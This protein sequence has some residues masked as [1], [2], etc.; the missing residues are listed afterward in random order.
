MPRCTCFCGA[1]YKVP[2]ASLGKESQCKQCGVVFT[3]TEDDATLTVAPP[4]ESDEPSELAPTQGQLFA[5]PGAPGHLAN[6]ETFAASVPREVLRR[7]YSRDVLWTFL[8]PTSM[9]NLFAF[10]AI[11]FVFALARIAIAPLGFL[12]IIAWFLLFG[13][14]SAFRFEIIGS[15]A[16]GH[17]D[18]PTAMGLRNFAA[19]LVGPLLGWIGSWLVVMFPAMLYVAYA[20]DQR[21]LSPGGVVGL[22]QGGVRGVCLGSTG[23]MPALTVLIALGVAAWP[24]VVLCIVM[25][26]FSTLY[27]PDLMTRTV[28][29][30]MPRYVTTILLIAATLAFEA[31]VES[32]KLPWTSSA[33]IAPPRGPASLFAPKLFI[34]T[35]GLQVYLDIVRMRLIGLYYFHGKTGFAWSWE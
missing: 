18:L 34:T 35:V 6:E 9:G 20:L 26:G 14:Y 13:W 15:A 33:A 22:L 5:P 4:I 17:E 1:K 2:T 31:V 32:G 27:R 23:D 21:I 8:F 24:I 25:G 3:L 30:T 28:V 10:L 29:N 16:A 11:W 7:S 12:F 19:D